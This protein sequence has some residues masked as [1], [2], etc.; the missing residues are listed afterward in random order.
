MN[1][2]LHDENNSIA[3]APNDAVPL[4]AMPSRSEGRVGSNWRNIDDAINYFHRADDG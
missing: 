3:I 2:Q 1:Y 4:P